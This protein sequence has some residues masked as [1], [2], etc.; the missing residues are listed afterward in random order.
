MKIRSLA[1]ELFYAHRQKD[2][3]KLVVTILNLAKA[4][5]KFEII[6]SYKCFESYKQTNSI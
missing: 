5:E 3:K 1:A 2:M 4:P 6:P